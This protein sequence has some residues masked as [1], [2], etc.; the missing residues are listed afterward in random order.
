[1][2]NEDSNKLVFIL[3]IQCFVL[4]FMY[5][6]SVMKGTL[7]NSALND[8]LKPFEAHSQNIIKYPRLQT[9][10]NYSFGLLYQIRMLA[11]YE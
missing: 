6:I 10:I 5:Y 7:F 9:L 1:M 4:I 11:Q 2:Q 3:Y 8:Y